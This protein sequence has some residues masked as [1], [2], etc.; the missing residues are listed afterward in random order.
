MKCLTIERQRNKYKNKYTIFG[1]TNVEIENIPEY[2]N[3]MD[4]YDKINDYHLNTNNYR[5]NALKQILISYKN[6]SK[7]QFFKI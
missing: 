5:I 1:I 6:S 4:R 2:V 3:D 7:E